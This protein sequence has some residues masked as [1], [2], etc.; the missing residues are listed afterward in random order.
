MLRSSALVVLGLLSWTIDGMPAAAED[1]MR[2]LPPSTA[3][4]DPPI[5]YEEIPRGID[6]RS[7]DMSR[8]PDLRPLEFYLRSWQLLPDGLMYRSYLAGGRE[9]RISSHFFAEKDKGSLWDATLGGR[10]GLVRYGNC[11]P[12]LPQGWQLDVE[13]AAFPRLTLNEDRD[14]VSVDFR[15]GVPLTVRQGA[16]ESKFAYYHLSSH[17]ADEWMLLHPAVPPRINYS[18]DVLV[19]GVA[20]RPNEDLRL[21]A[22]TGWA[23]W[24]DGGSEPWEFQFGIDY[25]PARPTGNQGA[26]FF[27]VNGRIREEVNWGGN[28]TVQTGWQWRGRTGRL[29]RVGMHYF[30]GQSDQ[31]QFFQEHE[32]QI[33]G[34]IWYDF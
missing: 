18:R 10:V 8:P 21:Y 20:L 22:E 6:P 28:F 25:S 27:A 15:V 1:Q 17:M 2:A 24:S 5:V 14:L 34:G 23:F 16:F 26:P 30:N 4:V 19:W 11:D 3:F 29:L 33:G 32:E 12:L 31:Y 13:G 9:P 7:I